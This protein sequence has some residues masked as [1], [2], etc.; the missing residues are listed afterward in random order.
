MLEDAARGEVVE[1][2]LDRLIER[3]A[4]KA[5]PEQRRVED[6]WREQERAHRERSRRENRAVWYAHEMRMC[7]LHEGLAREHAEKALGLLGGAEE[8]PSFRSRGRGSA[9]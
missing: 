1:K 7:E 9:V 4:L 3:R 6:L 8:A 2:E 5:G